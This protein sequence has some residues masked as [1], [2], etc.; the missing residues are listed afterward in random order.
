MRLLFGERLAPDAAH[1]ARRARG[2]PR[3]PQIPLWVKRMGGMAVVKVPYANAGQGVWTIVNDEELAAFMLIQHHYQSFIVQAR[4]DSRPGGAPRTHVCRAHAARRNSLVSVG[5]RCQPS[6][7]LSMS[8]GCGGCFRS[9]HADSLLCR[10]CHLP[11]TR[12]R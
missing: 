6:F 12:R 1:G 2:A 4:P 9:A 3:A 7:S 10:L 11:A 5:G 8:S